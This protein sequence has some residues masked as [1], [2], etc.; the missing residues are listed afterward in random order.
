[1]WFLGLWKILFY[2]VKRFLYYLDFDFQIP[3]GPHDPFIKTKQ[4]SFSVF[5]YLRDLEWRQRELDGETE[6]IYIA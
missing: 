3:N 6:R 1:M 4:T 2:S 5:F